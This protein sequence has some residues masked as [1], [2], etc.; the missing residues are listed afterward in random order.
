[1]IRCGRQDWSVSSFGESINAM[2]ENISLLLPSRSTH[3][4]PSGSWQKPGDS[5]SRWKCK[6]AVPRTRVPTY[7]R[8]APP[9]TVIPEKSTTTPST[10]FYTFKVVIHTYAFFSSISCSLLASWIA[11]YPLHLY[12]KYYSWRD[13]LRHPVSIR[14]K[15]NGQKQRTEIAAHD[16]K[17]SWRTI[18]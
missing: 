18:I 14:R 11:K 9:N 8:W 2:T 6:R 4:L 13:R 15:T 5:T 17:I 1:M 7:S 16:C 12:P 10:W 3:M